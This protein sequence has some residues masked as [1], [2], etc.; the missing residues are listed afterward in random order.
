MVPSSFWWLNAKSKTPDNTHC[1]EAEDVVLYQTRDFE[2]AY[3][4]KWMA[5]FTMT[6]YIHIY[7]TQQYH[8]KKKLLLA[9]ARLRK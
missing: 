5:V 3:T 6:V 2:D 7:D 9:G 1:T 8:L 4:S